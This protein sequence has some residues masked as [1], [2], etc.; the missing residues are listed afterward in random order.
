MASTSWYPRTESRNSVNPPLHSSLGNCDDGDE[1]EQATD[2]LLEKTQQ[3]P[4]MATT[5]SGER[6]CRL[7]LSK[8]QKLKPIFPPDG[9]PDEALLQ[10]ILG[11]LTITIS[12]D[13]DYDTFICG[14][15][16][17]EVTKFFLYKEQCLANDSI[18]RSR[19]KPSKN[20]FFED[21]TI[22][23]NNVEVVELS[24]GSV[25][26]ADDY[27]N[28][29]DDELEEMQGEP[30]DSDEFDIREDS[31]DEE[32][33]R[34]AGAPLMLKP[35]PKQRARRENVQDFYHGGYRYTCATSRANGKI[36]W[37]CMYK[38]KLKCRAA[39]LVAPN[40]TV[41]RGPNNHN[42]YA[43]GKKAECPSE[44]FILDVHTGRK[45]HYRMITSDR[46]GVNP[47]QLVCNGYKYRYARSTQK[48]TTYWRCMKHNGKENCKAVLSFRLDFS[49]CSSNGHQHNHPA[50]FDMKLPSPTVEE[51]PEEQSWLGP[52]SDD[53]GK[54][55]APEGFRIRSANGAVNKTKNAS[56][57]WNVLMHKGYEFGFPR[58]ERKNLKW[59]CYKKSLFNCPAN[60][61]TTRSG[62]V[63][64]ESDW[65]HNH[66]PNDDYDKNTI[67]EGYMQDA[68]N[69][70]AQVYYKLIPG[71][72]GQRF[73]LYKGYRY[74]SDRL[75]SDGRIAWKCTK[76]KVFVVIGG[77]FAHFEE[78]GDD[79]EHPTM[80]VE[81]EEAGVEGMPSSH[82]Q[83]QHHDGGDEQEE[84][85]Y[86]GSVIVKEEQTADE[87]DDSN[88]DDELIIPE[89]TMD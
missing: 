59:A 6:F 29:K 85:S 54:V 31:G 88:D 30:I 74:S 84:D 21:D 57:R 53:G 78:R 86:D 2:H 8:E 75:I 83:Q 15:C 69:E 63:L 16:V 72:R 82:P 64:K 76:C 10:R 42:H 12:F 39:I 52:E 33:F 26:G 13:E 61:Y 47:I 49:S 62:R 48:Q 7:C 41:T 32:R 22:P 43:E 4:L 51:P 71:K 77:R 44:G 50:Q 35:L 14:I 28:D 45:V 25:G 23:A 18:I 36:H 27:G 70:G 24:D 46:S 65:A 89:T 38:S 60:V 87:N 1:E 37:R 40:G 34:V 79:H 81:D 55:V 68:K 19:R 67:I 58:A 9:A 66:G 5:S 20:Y 11:C 56:G 3:V 17:Q 80:D 73:V